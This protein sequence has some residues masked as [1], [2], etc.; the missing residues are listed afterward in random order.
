MQIYLVGGAIRDRILGLPVEECDW[1][2]VGATPA[3]MIAQGFQPIGKAFP[4]FLHPETHEEYALARTE[5]KISQGYKG[6]TFYTDPDV[7]LEQDLKRRDLTINAIAQDMHGHRID[8]FHGEEDIQKKIFRHVSAAF[9]ED[10]VRILR[11]AR[12]ATKLTQFRLHPETLRL[13]R[14]MV[15][16]GEVDALVAERVWQEFQRA[17]TNEDPARFFLIL[18][19][20]HA[21]THLFPQ[22]NNNGRGLQCL[23]QTKKTLTPPERFALLTHDL[24]AL[25]LKNLIQRYKIPNQYAELA[26]LVCHHWQHFQKLKPHHAHELLTMLISCDALRRPDRFYHFLTV[27]ETADEAQPLARQKT[28][29]L[30]QSLQIIND[31]DT[32]PLQEQGVTG[33]AFAQRLNEIRLAALEKML[34]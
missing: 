11:V 14:S 2:V 13:M 30:K 33:K 31:I 22:I 15:D 26:L 23:Q 12:L 29:V 19:D 7:T 20:C 6:F 3:Q 32:A 10:P 17:L 18:N 16:A 24:N 5:R 25:D 21:L 27:L 34:I 4:V 1:V 9:Q 8:P 28:V